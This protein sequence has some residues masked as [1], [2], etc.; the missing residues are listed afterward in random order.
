MVWDGIE[1][2]NKATDHD[3]L[4][5]VV[6]ILTNHVENFNQH[7]TDDKAAFDEIGKR[8]WNHAKFIYIGIGIVA[9]LEVLGG[10]PVTNTV[11]PVHYCK[12]FLGPVVR[13]HHGYVFFFQQTAARKHKKA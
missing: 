12:D 4:I 8:L 13:G 11:F 2:R 9:V 6:Q 10:R 5:Q 7:V 3:T 1:R